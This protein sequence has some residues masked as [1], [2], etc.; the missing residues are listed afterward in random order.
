MNIA[1][2]SFLAAAAVG[3]IGIG[4]LTA[5]LAANAQSSDSENL[6]D[7]IASTFNINKDE[8]QK[9][10][11]ENR[12]ERKAEFEQKQQ[13]RLD[14]AVADG[15]ITAEQKD[16]IVAK[17]EELKSFKE[18]LKDKT[19]DERKQAFQE[20]RDSLKSWAE[21]NN[22]PLNYLKPHKGPHHGGFHDRA[23]H[24]ENDG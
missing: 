8:V 5:T 11:E 9:V 13:E 10:F 24:N 22:I 3:T 19:K 20:N 6:V 15:K 16:L 7:K 18:S 2:K 14:Q 12:S 1:K 23:N 4:S 17:F 21:D